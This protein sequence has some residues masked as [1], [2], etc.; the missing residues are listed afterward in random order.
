MKILCPETKTE[1][2]SVPVEDLGLLMLDHYQI[3]ISQ[4]DSENDGK[5]CS[6]G[7]L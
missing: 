7:E 6:G 1:K 4:S 2:G 5:Q 3:T